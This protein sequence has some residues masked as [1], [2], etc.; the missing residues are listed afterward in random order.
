MLLVEVVH[1]HDCALHLVE[2]FVLQGCRE[3]R[4]LFQQLEVD[5][6]AI[7]IRHDYHLLCLTT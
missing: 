2:D 3:L 5:H 6:F 7:L 4:Q 1:C